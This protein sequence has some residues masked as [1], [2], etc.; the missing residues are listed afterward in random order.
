MKVAEALSEY[1]KKSRLP[2]L[3]A[4][5]GVSAQGGLPSW[6]GYLSSLASAAG[7]YDPYIKF[8]I[9][10]AINDGALIDAASFYFMCREMPDSQR[11]SALQEPLL[12]F[13]W[14][15][16]AYLAKLPFQ[17]VATTNFDR[18]LFAAYAKAEGVAAREVNIDDPTLSA[19]KF[20]DDF[21]IARIH[22]R[23][24]IPLSMRLSKDHFALLPSNEA[25][26][27]F[28]EHLFTR[29]QV[30][31]LGFS[32]LD[33]AIAAVLKSVRAKTEGMHGQEHWA[34]VP[35]GIGT[36]FVAELE[37][38][39]IRRIEY[40]PANH[41]R[42]LWEGIEAFAR[43]LNVKLPSM[44]DVRDV[45]FATAKQYLANAYAR[46]RL[47]RQREPLAQAMAEGVVSGMISKARAGITEEELVLQVARELT[48]SEDVTRTLVA[49]A[50]ADL[51]RDGICGVTPADDAIRYVPR[52]EAGLAY[53]AAVARLVDGVVQRYRLQEGGADTAEVRAY[54]AA[55][56]GELLLQRGWELGAAYAGRRMPEDVDLSSVMDRISGRG[57]RNTE[58]VKLGRALKDLLIRPDD[59][60]A[61]LLA[62]LGRTA[63]GLE[64]L[65]ESPHD[66]LFLTRAL[67]ERLYFD[68]NVVMPAI[69]KGHPLHE[70]FSVTMRALKEAAGATATGPSLRV[71]DG[72]LNEIVSHRRLA[73]E[74]M[75]GGNGD[76]ALWEERA[77]GLFGTA[78][79]NVFVGA[80]FN[81]KLTDREISFRD[82][83]R[84]FAPY[85]NERQLKEHL[86][87]LG[88]EVVYENRANKLDLPDILHCLD[89]FY[90]TKFEHQK[91]S[92]I[93]VRHDAVQLSILNADLAEQRRSVF[94][95]ADRGI[96]FALESDGYGSVANSVLTHLGLT[97][98][99]ELLVGRLASP[100]GV[101]SLL[102]MSPVSSDS[103]RIRSYLV[104]LAL[105]EHS[106]AAAMYLPDVIGEIVEDAGFELDRKNLKLETES[107]SDRIEIGR[108]LERY[109]KDF[110][111]KM[112]AEIDRAKKG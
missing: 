20:A 46:S 99:V 25:Y 9:D 53:E 34:L 45:P 73:I 109:E 79:V 102:W 54:L 28:L 14:E 48:L 7:E 80:F 110:F 42:E 108:V 2:I 88:F 36:E 6:S 107:K 35:K 58:F 104:G 98:M 91:K 67:P 83:L 33:P 11:L 103:E 57:I 37:R 23:V 32:F 52:S 74:S 22:G 12:K 8:V 61:I 38:H 72:F 60:E 87:S 93:V 112:N 27:G 81:F 77:V 13:D 5:A 64:L 59:E 78:N 21:F 111:R 90:A 19:A 30:L 50:L 47:G 41:H 55:V 97:Q 4:G 105:K 69:T 26:V 82:F 39:S 106:V 49:R 44:A 56:V 86:D 66:S 65:L 40:D 10:K 70:L 24:E 51:T 76:G 31:F 94:V 89:K 29:R 75:E 96:R 62:D 84:K 43:Q 3:F 100:R 85:E 101:A 16:L 71:Y 68:A 17:A 63:F 92:P 18:V 15:R 95:S 1:F